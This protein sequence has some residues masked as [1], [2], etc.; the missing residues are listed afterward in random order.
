MI[1]DLSWK[2]AA[3]SQYPRDG[4]MG[5]AM[6]TERYR[7]V[8]WRDKVTG[9][10]RARELYDHDMDAMENVNIADRVNPDTLHKLAAQLSLRCP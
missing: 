8:E 9:N 7:Y 10:V 6:R 1:P 5:Y 2:T 4:V 3:F